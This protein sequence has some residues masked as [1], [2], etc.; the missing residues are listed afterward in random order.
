MKNLFYVGGILAAT[1]FLAIGC[2][3]TAEANVGV[4]AGYQNNNVTDEQGLVLDVS[5]VT[6]NNI[7]LGVNT[8]TQVDKGRLLTYGV[9]AGVPVAL[10]NTPVTVTPSLGVDRYRVEDETVGNVALNFDYKFDTTTYAT[11]QTKYSKEFD[12]SE[13]DLDGGSYT[14]GITKLF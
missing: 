3:K 4:L 8:L 13:Y 2:V 14:F 1:S 12:S 6:D 9:Y 5:T 10:Q 11:I 7:K